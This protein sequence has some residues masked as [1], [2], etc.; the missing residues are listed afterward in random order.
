[1]PTDNAEGETI[2]IDDSAK[3]YFKEVG[4]EGQTSQ[5]STDGR[6]LFNINDLAATNYCTVDI[7]KDIMTLTTDSTNGAQ[8]AT[9][10]SKN[11]DAEETYR[12]SF[13]SKK[14]VKGTNGIPLTRITVYGSNDDSSYTFLTYLGAD[15]PTQGQEYEFSH[16]FTGYSYYRFFIY[17]NASTPVTLEEKTQYYDILL[18]KS[19]ETDNTW[20]PYTGGI[21]RTKSILSISY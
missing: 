6:Q 17:N 20:E 9:Y 5:V 21:P 12:F 15:S 3:Y 8:F 13:K 19:T 10:Y 11:L 4:V 14:V 16:D 1:M 7:E 2:D 18:R